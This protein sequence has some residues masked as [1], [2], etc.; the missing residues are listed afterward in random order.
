MTQKQYLE[1]VKGVDT[2][3]DYA[4][5]SLALKLQAN[6]KQ[7]AELG[8]ALEQ[9]NIKSQYMLQISGIYL[10]ALTQ[11]GQAGKTCAAADKLAAANSKDGDALLIA[12][13]CSLRQNNYRAR[14]RQRHARRGGDCYQS[15]A[16]RSERLRSGQQE[17]RDAGAR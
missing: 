5:Y 1:Y 3:A 8:A 17:S 10:N 4:L 12:A 14:G 2:Y 6:P 9:Q 11:S 7:L 15:E 13:D 16:G